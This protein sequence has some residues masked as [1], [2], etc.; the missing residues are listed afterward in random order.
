MACSPGSGSTWRLSAACRKPYGALPTYSSFAFL[1]RIASRVRSPMASRSHWLTET[2]ILR[3]SLPEALP[4]SSDSATDTNE[5]PRRWNCSNRTAKSF[6]DLVRR[7][8]LATITIPTARDWTISRM[9]TMPGRSRS[10]ALSPAVNQDVQ[11]LDVVDGGHC[12]DL[13]DLRFQGNAP[14]GLLVC[15]YPHVTDRLCFHSLV[16][17]QHAKYGGHKLSGYPMRLIT[18]PV[19]TP[20]GEPTEASAAC[21]QRGGNA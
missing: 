18:G 16:P 21:T 13:L 3:T 5:T 12:P 15:R 2:M 6:T 11:Q 4:V 7:S 19:K 1:C 20:A 10:L 9:R 17:F 14:V 8:S